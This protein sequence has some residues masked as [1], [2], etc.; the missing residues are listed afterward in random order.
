[1]RD[2]RGRDGD[3]LGY[4]RLVRYDTSAI[5]VVASPEELLRVEM[6]RQ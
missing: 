2:L 4:R 3:D 5:A 1:M 6:A